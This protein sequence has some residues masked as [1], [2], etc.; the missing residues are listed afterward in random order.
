M[1]PENIYSCYKETNDSWFISSDEQSS[2]S[3]V[4]VILVCY[5]ENISY[6]LC[7][8]NNECYFSKAFDSTSTPS[9]LITFLNILKMDVVDKKYFEEN[10]FGSIDKSY[11]PERKTK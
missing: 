4:K 11:K 8:G 6:V 3:L 1:I 2:I 9:A 5:E 10:E 7:S